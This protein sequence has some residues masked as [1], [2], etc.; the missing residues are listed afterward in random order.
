MTE[1]KKINISLVKKIGKMTYEE[2]VKRLEEVV[3]IL[4]SKQVDLD[5]M[6]N[7][8]EEGKALHQHCNN[9]LESARMKIEEID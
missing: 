8:Y 4:S 9:L 6:I 1:D 5:K 7:L 2:A 3:E